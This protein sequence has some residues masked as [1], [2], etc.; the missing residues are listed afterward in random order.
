MGL[1]L[2]LTSVAGKTEKEVVHSLANF[3][4][5]REGGLEKETLSSNHDHCCIIEEAGGNSTILYPYAFL[6]WDEASEFISKDLNAPVFSFHIHDGDLWMYTLFVNGEMADQFNPVPGYWDEISEEEAESWKGN[7][8]IVASHLKNVPA[9]EIEKYLVRWDPDASGE[10]KAYPTDEF[11]MAEDWQL[12]DFMKK[13]QLPYPQVD[14]ANN[15]AS[16]YKIW[17]KELALKA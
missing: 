2:S 17:T 9:A 15:T 8:S 1:F 11:H 7:A 10:E 14:Q 5:S 12:L 3:A 4:K 6:E 16:T 13:L